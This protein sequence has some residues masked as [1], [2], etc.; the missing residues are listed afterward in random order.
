MVLGVLGW[1]VSALANPWA[2]IDPSRVDGL[3]DPVFLEPRAGWQSQIRDETGSVRVFVADDATAAWGWFEAQVGTTRRAL[4][5]V[6]FPAEYAV[7]DARNLLLFVDGNVA[8]RVHREAGEVMA[9]GQALYER[10]EAATPWPSSPSVALGD[11]REVHVEG[12]WRHVRVQ[13][14]LA[15]DP[16]TLRPRPVSVIPGEDGHYALSVAVGQV[17]VVVWDRFGRWAR[18]AARA[19]MDESLTVGP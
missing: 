7:G 14:A 5:E 19:S 10:L 12:Q 11:G 6:P 9:L 16:V 1:A 17:D 18:T 13:P 3:V 8:V 15:S 4:P 2:G